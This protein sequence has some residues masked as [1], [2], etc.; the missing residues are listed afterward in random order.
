[1]NFRYEALNY[2]AFVAF[3][4]GIATLMTGGAA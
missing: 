1:M 2:A 4:A 3:L